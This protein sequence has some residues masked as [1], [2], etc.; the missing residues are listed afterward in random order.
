MS[1]P[2]EKPNPPPTIIVQQSGGEGVVSGFKFGCGC[3]LVI[4]LVIILAGIF[5]SVTATRT[6]RTNYTTNVP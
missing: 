4:V 2:S 3:L 5:A 1:Q 6:L